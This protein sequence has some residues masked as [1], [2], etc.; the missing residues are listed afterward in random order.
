MRFPR[1]F[2]LL[3]ILTLF[4][5]LFSYAEKIPKGFVYLKDVAPSI[6]QDMRYAGYHNFVGRPIKGY[7]AKACILT[8]QAAKALA[9]VQTTLLKSNLSLKV[10]DCYRPQSASNDFMAWSKNRK[11]TKMKG[12]FYPRVSKNRLFKLGY[13][14]KKSGHSRGSTVDL[15]I[16]PIPTPPEAHYVRGQP[17]KSCFSPYL[18]R[19]RDNSIDMGTGYDCLDSL[20]Q[21]FNPRV[22]I[23]S[24]DNRMLLRHIMQKYGFAPY[25][26]E[27]WHFTLKNEPYKNTYFYFP[28]LS[29]K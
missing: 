8:R 16:V 26:K 17:L 22:G 15:T 25:T 13:I 11:N 9:R 28:I 5:P 4:F 12:E 10:Y 23:V 1:L 18:K 21:A 24:Y 2:R 19:Y 3:L 7:H 27:W 20:T 29:E 6:L 14:A